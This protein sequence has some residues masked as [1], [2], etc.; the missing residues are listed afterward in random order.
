MANVNITNNI[1]SSWHMS[2][3]D[4]TNLVENSLGKLN[5][6]TNCIVEIIFATRPTI[7]RLNRQFRNKDYPTDILSFPQIRIPGEQLCLLGSLVVCPA[8]VRE[9]RE[10]PAD[11]IKHGLLHLLGYDHETNESLWNEKANIINCEM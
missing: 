1:P 2:R 9:K 7:Q 4:L 8:V 11:V 10:S 5:T 3:T 6:D